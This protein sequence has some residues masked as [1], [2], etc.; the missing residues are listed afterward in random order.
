AHL[1]KASRQV[2]D[3][4]PALRSSID[5][6]ARYGLQIVEETQLL[7]GNGTGNN[8]HGMIPQAEDY[9]HPSG[10]GVIQSE[11]RLDRIRLAALQVTLADYP[12]TGVIVHPTDWAAMEML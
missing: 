10:I 6:R 12:S 2:L 4:L 3:D 5:A 7:Y 11:Q 9:S 8:L 1:F